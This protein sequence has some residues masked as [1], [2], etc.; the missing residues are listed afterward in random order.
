M[1]EK[2]KNK[3]LIVIIIAL[4]L[5]I[6]GVI[7]AV[8]LINNNAKTNGKSEETETETNW[9]EELASAGL[10][11]K[12]TSVS[13]SKNGFQVDFIN[14][15]QGDCA[16]VRCNGKNM[17]IDCGEAEYYEIVRNFLVN[18]GIEKIDI[19]IASHP[20]SDHIGGMSR[21]FEDFDIDT[22]I[23]P[24]IKKHKELKTDVY[25]TFSEA[26]ID[27]KINPVFSVAGDE[28]F[29]DDAKITI[30]G[31]VKADKEINNMSVVAM[32]EYGEKKFLFAGDAEKNAEELLLKSGQN[33]D[34]DV[35]KVSHHGSKDSSD[36]KFL[37]AASPDFAVI[38]VG[39]YNEYNHPDGITLKN[40]YKEDAEVYRT[41][42]DGTVSFYVESENDD[43]V[44][45]A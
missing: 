33:L 28:F 45:V 14:V 12:N 18:N 22:L 26:I 16:L 11:P 29:L 6:A 36:V 31:P 5:V 21:L 34:C 42:Y 17:L 41:D 10:I 27:Y 2:R 23:M 20:H 37:K 25:K 38:S 13:D 1:A 15:G 7:T 8:V 24:E 9:A 32:V 30:L 40:L 39:K 43:I 35:L 19:V 3:K 4:I 44:Y